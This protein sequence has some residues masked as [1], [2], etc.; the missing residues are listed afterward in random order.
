M[1]HLILAS[2]SPRRHEL[3]ARL[4]PDFTILTSPVEEVGSTLMPEW[5]AEPIELPQPYL[6]PEEHDPRLWA[7]RKAMDVVAT[8]AIPIGMLVL[9]ADTVVVGST[10]LLGKPRDAAH[11]RAILQTLR[12]IEH[13]VVTGFVVLRAADGFKADTIHQGAT[14]TKVVMGDYS[15]AQIEAYIA[16]GESM[17]KAGAYALQG[18]GGKLVDRVEGCRTNVVGLPLCT[19][20]RALE[21]GG[22]QLLAVP[23]SGYCGYCLIEESAASE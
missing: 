21:A 11:A 22:T 9:G 3:L 15:D 13:Y 6:V 12:G 17:D 18:L 14:V 8:N 23:E 19:V 10:E 4:T 20:R 2:G 16:N 5:H 7:W 1:T